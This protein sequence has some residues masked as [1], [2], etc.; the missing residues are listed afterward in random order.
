MQTPDP[1]SIFVELK[2]ETAEA[3]ARVQ[4]LLGSQM[5]LPEDPLPEQLRALITRDLRV[6]EGASVV[7]T[8]NEVNERHG[9][10]VLVRRIF[11]GCPN[12]L[13]VRSR[14][15]YDGA[16]DFGAVS[17]LVNHRDS[18]RYQ[19][20]FNLIQALRG[21]TISRIVCIPYYASDVLTAIALKDLFGV[22]LCTYIMDDHNLY[23]DGIP[24][25][26]M[27]EMLH[28]SALRLA[29]S[30]PMRDAYERK[31][32][33]KFW[34]LPPIVQDELICSRPLPPTEA[35]L[36]SKRG[37]LIGNVWG[38]KWLE[39]LRRTVKNSG[40]TLDWYASLPPWRALSAADL[41]RDGLR[42]QG[43]LPEPVLAERLQNY[44]FAVL[45]SGTLDA[46]D[47]KQAIARLSLPTRVLF[48]MA[49]AGLPILVLGS[50][51]TAAASFIERF[52]IGVVT[53]YDGASFRR[54]AE[55]LSDP[56]T[57][58]QI[59][60]R[61]A[62]AAPAFAAGGV[63]E[64]LWRSLEMGEPC[65]GRFEELMPRQAA[66]LVPY[67]EPPIP[68]VHSDYR[69]DYRTLRRLGRYFTPDFVV[70]VGASSGVWSHVAALVFPKAR[71]V[72]VEP[73]HDAHA[74]ADNFAHRRQHPEFEWV[75]AA[76]SN[77][78]GTVT[79]QASG[80]LYGSSLLPIADARSYQPIK[81]EAI[82]LDALARQKN[83][84]GRG[85]LKIDVQCAEHLVL[86]GAG[87]ML[88]QVGAL[89][90]ELSLEPAAPGAK[91]L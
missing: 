52:G 54:A 64:W 77:Q 73:L 49:A 27:E 29:I 72:L 82:T 13:S 31:Y 62:A 69:A 85:L 74:Q 40:L 66:D 71:F 56:A 59:R 79:L 32:G 86:E 9:T 10:G 21:S 57:Q 50:A 63:G 87:K 17:V 46:S 30:A 22:P 36:R 33:L 14:D 55:Q 24:D 42:L 12:I 34:L 2:G 61:A 90:I 16:H 47:D 3:R 65:D 15:D 23:S 8:G 11:A 80:D 75:Q 89:L 5:V 84:T 44:P 70:D 48:L 67:I 43:F 35:V 1:L 6:L 76:V 28:K 91:F 60:A 7:I 25:G 81:A 39:R 58:Q 88:Q 18:R 78:T 19:I 41:E 51:R 53:D 20:F 37:I 26:L 45:P 68:A 83:L 4:E 38:E